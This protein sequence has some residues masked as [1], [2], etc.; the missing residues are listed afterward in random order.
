MLSPLLVHTAKDTPD[1]Q[2]AT[3]SNVQSQKAGSS[4]HRPDSML[5]RRD[6]GSDGGKA[7]PSIAVK[8]PSE[9]SEICSSITST[10]DAF[11]HAFQSLELVANES[12][13]HRFST[14]VSTNFS[15]PGYK[16]KRGSKEYFNSR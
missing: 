9:Y 7:M 15:L 14:S 5:E 1:A 3:Q 11:P 13:P 2:Q 6:F 8:S 16:A 4:R 10:S 12:L